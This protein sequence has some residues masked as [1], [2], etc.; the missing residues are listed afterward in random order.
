[1]IHGLTYAARA[2]PQHESGYLKLAEKAFDFVVKHLRR[3]DGSLIR[4][5]YVDEAGNYTKL[6]VTILYS[7]IQLILS[8]DFNMF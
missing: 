6:Y 2:L 7:S 3:E 5:A 4:S 8:I 1:M